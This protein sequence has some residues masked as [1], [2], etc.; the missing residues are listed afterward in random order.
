[1]SEC[2]STISARNKSKLPP[3]G[4][5]VLP[6]FHTLVSSLFKVTH[7]VKSVL[8]NYVRAYT[9]TKKTPKTSQQWRARLSAVSLHLDR[10][11]V[12]L[13]ERMT[14]LA[15]A[16]A[17]MLPCR[18]LFWEANQ[19]IVTHFSQVTDWFSTKP[20]TETGLFH[21]HVGA[22]FTASDNTAVITVA[23]SLA[24]CSKTLFR[25]CRTMPSAH[26]C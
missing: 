5:A 9:G 16:L 24:S 21:I 19:V 25:C 13:G 20:G 1:M 26:A 23:L 18:K 7:S 11:H 3:K 6:V 12:L 10:P 8:H 17:L 15:A 14:S 22:S 2:N 4:T